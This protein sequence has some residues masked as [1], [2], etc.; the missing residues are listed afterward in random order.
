MNAQRRVR[1]IWH[2]RLMNSKVCE[3]DKNEI[4]CNRLMAKLWGLRNLTS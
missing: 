4:P 2:L 1:L 3:E